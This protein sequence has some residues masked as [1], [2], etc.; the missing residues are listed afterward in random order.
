[1]LEDGPL[2]SM[3]V[4]SNIGRRLVHSD[5][6]IG[7]TKPRTNRSH[8]TTTPS[9]ILGQVSIVYTNYPLHYTYLLQDDRSKALKVRISVARIRY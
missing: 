8:A 7:E 3:S 9:R 6:H 2:Q 5:L 4:T 1:M